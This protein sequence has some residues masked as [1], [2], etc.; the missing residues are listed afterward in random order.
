MSLLVDSTLIGSQLVLIT[1]GTAHIWQAPSN[2]LW[3]MPCRDVVTRLGAEVNRLPLG[4]IQNPD[5]AAKAHPQ[6]SSSLAD[7]RY[8]DSV[9]HMASFCEISA[10]HGALGRFPGREVMCIVKD[11][12]ASKVAAAARTPQSSNS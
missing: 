1:G 12:M 4:Q 3:P 8:S 5:L 11:Y 7:Q 9:R 6:S 2:T 10:A